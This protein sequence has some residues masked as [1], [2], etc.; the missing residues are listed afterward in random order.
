MVKAVGVVEGS[1]ADQTV[2]GRGADCRAYWEQGEL[3]I[4]LHASCKLMV[5]CT[6]GS[7]RAT[8]TGKGRDAGKESSSAGRTIPSVEDAMLEARM[9]ENRPVKRILNGQH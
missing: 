7:S 1:F 8:S 6:R 5:D 4:G 2:V 9:S 3:T